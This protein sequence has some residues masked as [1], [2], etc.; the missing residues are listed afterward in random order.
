[1]EYRRLGATGLEVSK[2]CLGMMSYGSSEWQPWV[3]PASDAEEFV[4]HALDLGINFFD[5]AD[6]YSGGLSE[7]ALGSAIARLT[8]R[9]QVVIATKVGLPM[10][11][12]PNHGGLSRKHIM[13][14]IDSSLKRLGTDYVDIFQLH[15]ADPATP[16][17]ETMEAL[18]DV[19]RAGKALYV[20]ASNFNLWQFSAGLIASAR[21]S[22]IK[23]SS[24]QLQYNLAYREEEREMIPF[25]MDQGIGVIVYSPLA[26]GLLSGNRFGNVAL[27]SREA[28]RAGRDAKAFAIYG[29]DTDLGIAERVRE[30]AA[31]HGVSS[32]RVALA[33]LHGKKSVA[34]VLCGALELSHLDDAVAAVGL[35]LSED[36]VRFIEEPYRTQPLKDDAFHV[37]DRLASRPATASKFAS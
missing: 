37:V 33:W 7:Q 35:V 21:A 3:L 13:A 1:M 17:E 15:R 18:T 29:S 16:I 23:F 34:S 24:M 14:S 22:L 25:C 36:D 6:A 9:H 19:V 2:V 8:Q 12:R 20:G 32:A 30:V 26:R 27:T 28:V 31:R 4:R 5:S 10:S 11:D